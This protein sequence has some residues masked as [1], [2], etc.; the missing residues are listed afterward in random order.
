[1]DG[2]SVDVDWMD[3]AYLCGKGQQSGMCEMDVDQH[4]REGDRSSEEGTSLS[5]SS[6]V[7]FSLTTGGSLSPLQVE[8]SLTRVS[9]SSRLCLFV[10]WCVST[11][12]SS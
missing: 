8:R 5:L 1:M 12:T 6:T 11:V 2:W 4:V 9:L 10:R 7:D 3:C